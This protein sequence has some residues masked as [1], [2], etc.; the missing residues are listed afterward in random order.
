MRPPSRLCAVIV[1]G[2][3]VAGSAAMS[4][5]RA[6][7]DPTL[8]ATPVPADTDLA[9]T[10]EHWPFSAAVHLELNAPGA[11]PV[12]SP[13]PDSAGSFRAALHVPIG[14]T[15]GTYLLSACQLCD[16]IDGNGAGTQ[17]NVDVLAATVTFDPSSA[18]AGDPVT[19]IGEGW[20]TTREVFLFTAESSTCDQHAAFAT[21]TPDGSFA[22]SVSTTV[23]SSQPG[24]YEFM[25]AQCEGS[26][27]VVS[28]L[29][30]FSIRPKAPTTSASTIPTT[31]PVTTTPPG[32]T[33]TGHAS[34]RQHVGPLGW[35]VLAIATAALMVIATQFLSHR[36]GHGGRPPKVRAQLDYRPAP[37]PEVG[38]VPPFVRHG[39][40]LLTE[41]RYGPVISTEERR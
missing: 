38:E 21:A 18:A 17:I 12:D 20:S 11:K 23:P 14:T 8:A 35:L 41:E 4:S 7:P 31:P 24:A 33:S 34:V 28:A 9:V 5:A 36:Q 16:P 37:A 29:E 30:S 22:F 40:R 1:A 6:A 2:F 3:L 15:P 27:V 26:K 19:A 10:G 25:A 32:R 39:I 13:P